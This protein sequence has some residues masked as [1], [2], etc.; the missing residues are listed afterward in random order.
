M[1]SHPLSKSLTKVR[2]NLKIMKISVIIATRN[3]KNDLKRT[4]ESFNKQTYKNFEIIVIDNASD[5]GTC[6]MMEKEFTYVKYLWLPINI[7]ILAINI[8]IEL[9][10][11]DIIWRTDSDSN[12]ENEYVFEKVIKIFE[13]NPDIHIICAEDIEV[14]QNYSVWEWYPNE[15]DKINIPAKGYPAHT[16]AGT[17]AAIRKE[18]YDKIGGFWEFGFEEIEFSTRAILAGFNIRYFPNI[19]VHHF[20]SP[21]DRINSDRWIKVSKQLMRYY[22]KY[23]PLRIS[24][25]NTFYILLFQ[26]L[27]ALLSR[28]SLIVIIEGWLTMIVSMLNTIRNERRVVPD[29]KIEAITLNQSLIKQQLRFYLNKFKKFIT[30]WQNK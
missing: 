23:F 14:N 26:T 28:L 25:P 22:W 7:D 15:V 8:G 16:F 13:E 5:D 1:K 30:R 10:T 20:A 12:P 6:S 11:G 4:I 2:R 9:S 18:V 27:A 21:Q 3:R 19:R 17:G 24:I 29:D